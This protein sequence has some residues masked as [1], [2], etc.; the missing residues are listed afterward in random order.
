MTAIFSSPILRLP[1]WPQ[2]FLPGHTRST[3]WCV[4][5]TCRSSLPCSV[6][7]SVQS[8]PLR[9]GPWSCSLNNDPCQICILRPCRIS[10]LLPHQDRVQRSLCEETS[11]FWLE[12]THP[13]CLSAFPSFGLQS[14][15]AHFKSHSV[16]KTILRS[17]FSHDLHLQVWTLA[18]RSWRAQGCVMVC[19]GAKS[20]A[21][22]WWWL[23]K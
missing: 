10:C 3:A 13:P 1:P 15:L 11:M 21:S 5:S 8:H 6:Q 17:T 2:L 12:C 7:Q 23:H 20:G 19:G 22:S 16:F 14:Y 4:P 18:Q 9:P